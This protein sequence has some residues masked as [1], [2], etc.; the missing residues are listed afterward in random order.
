MIF[1]GETGRCK[2]WT[3]YSALN[4]L[5]RIVK[6]QR[7]EGFAV[8]FDYY[9]ISLASLYRHWLS[10][11]SE[12][13]KNDNLFYNLCNSDFL[14]FDDIG[15]RKSTD[16]FYDFF[17]D[18]V[19][20]RSMKVNHRTLFTTNLSAEALIGT[21]SER[22]VSRVVKGGDYIKFEGPDQRGRKLKDLT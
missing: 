5:L 20:K 18:V 1:Y 13:Y 14:A 4:D 2:T 8:S 10:N 17:M 12:P 22:F 16:G 7:E 19:D 9:F 3:A 6:K 21:Y 11:C 15:G